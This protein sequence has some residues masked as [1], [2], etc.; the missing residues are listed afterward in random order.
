MKLLVLLLVLMSATLAQATAS[1]QHNIAHLEEWGDVCVEL[2]DLSTECSEFTGGGPGH[3]HRERVTLTSAAEAYTQDDNQ[4]LWEYAATLDL[5]AVPIDG[6]AAESTM[7]ILHHNATITASSVEGLLPRR[8]RP[9]FFE[10]TYAGLN[11]PSIEV[12][13]GGDNDGALCG[14]ASECPGGVCLAVDVSPDV[15]VSRFTN[16]SAA[17]TVKFPTAFRALSA[18]SA[19][20]SEPPIGF[21]AED[22]P[23]G[24]VGSNTKPGIGFW[25]DGD[26]DMSLFDGDIRVGN[27][28]DL[29]EPGLDIMVGSGGIGSGVFN[30]GED[31]PIALSFANGAGTT[32]AANRVVILDPV[33]I[34]GEILFETTTTANDPR[35]LGVTLASI[36]NL[37]PGPIAVWGITDVQCTTPAVTTGDYLVT[38]TTAGLCQSGGS[39]P[40]SGAFGRALNDK[41]ASGPG[42]VKV[43]LHNAQPQSTPTPVV[44]A[45]PGPTS[46]PQCGGATTG[47]CGAQVLSIGPQLSGLTR[48]E[49]VYAALATVT[50]TPAPG[51]ATPTP[52]STAVTPTPTV[53]ATPLVKSD[54]GFVDVVGGANDVGLRIWNAARTTFHS[55]S[56]GAFGVLN[57]ISSSGIIGLGSATG[58]L[59]IRND[60]L[61][62]IGTAPTLGACG[63]GTPAIASYSTDGA[64]RIT[65]GLV[66]TSCVITFANAWATQPPSCFCNDETTTIAVRAVATTTTLTCLGAYVASDVIN[67][68]CTGME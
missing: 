14:A 7:S 2:F 32:V 50:A 16:I 42:L 45:T 46:T 9:Y 63:T 38:S 23:Q 53:T 30:G 33:D 40:V 39:V 64:G 4:G 62:L 17:R 3:W 56:A 48:A 55:I 43:L 8:A 44:T 59:R 1:P 11:S 22:Q 29:Y 41:D 31:L 18:S 6:F 26:D 52:T 13:I 25:A 21:F 57:I 10:A 37:D 19:C 58:I 12:C 5:S 61:V 24:Q 49:Q 20:C 15:L 67:Y 65:T 47:T 28:T 35:V 51:T 36:A 68:G 60:H 27:Y 54:G 66:T 34:G